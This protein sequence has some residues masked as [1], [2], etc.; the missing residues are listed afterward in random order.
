MLKVTQNLLASLVVGF[1]LFSYSNAD[2]Q[3]QSYEY[4]IDVD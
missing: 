1:M 2:A 4:S 3:Y